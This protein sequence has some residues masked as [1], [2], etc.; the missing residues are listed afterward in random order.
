MDTFRRGLKVE[1][2][3]LFGRRLFKGWVPIEAADISK[4]CEY[5]FN[6]P[7]IRLWTTHGTFTMGVQCS[8]YDK[9]TEFLNQNTSFDISTC[10]AHRWNVAL[11]RTSVLPAVWRYMKKLM[12]RNTHE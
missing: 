6:N 1:N 2:G 12:G 3:K 8:E 11:Y 5:S 9:V 4:V 7:F 10:L